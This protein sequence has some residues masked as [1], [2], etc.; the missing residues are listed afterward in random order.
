[1][2][3]GPLPIRVLLASLRLGDKTIS[4]CLVSAFRSLDCLQ[5]AIEL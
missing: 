4:D 3:T 1:M 5:P 2:A